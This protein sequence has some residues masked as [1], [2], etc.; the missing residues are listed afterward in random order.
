ML[1]LAP[2]P[3]GYH[4]LL[5]TILWPKDLNDFEFDYLSILPKTISRWWMTDTYY[6]HQSL[7]PR[8]NLQPGRWLLASS[9]I[10]TQIELPHF[11]SLALL[12]LCL[13]FQQV[14]PSFVSNEMLVTTVFEDD[15]WPTSHFASC[16]EPLQSPVQ[17]LISSSISSLTLDILFNLRL[18]S[19]TPI[20][21]FL[22]HRKNNSKLL[23]QSLA[24]VLLSPLQPVHTA[25]S[26]LWVLSSY[27]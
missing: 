14:I 7:A 27:I 26:D 17:P 21:P 16:H 6:S 5:L 13:N 9:K 3:P 10:L 1:I 20:Y 23:F 2:P 24:I 22:L 8:N 12:Q 11:Q 4:H 15:R 19:F 25:H 18:F